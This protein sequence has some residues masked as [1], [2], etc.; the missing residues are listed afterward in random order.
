MKH[1]QKAVW[2]SLPPW[3]QSVIV[4]VPSIFQVKKYPNSLPFAVF[5]FHKISFLTIWINIQKLTNLT[6]QPLHN[7]FWSSGGSLP[8]LSARPL[9]G[10]LPD[11]SGGPERTNN[12]SSIRGN[13]R[14][15]V[16]L[17]A[18]CLDYKVIKIGEVL[19]L[20]T[21]FC[22]TRWII[23]PVLHHIML[24]NIGKLLNNWEDV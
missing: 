4:I 6:W 14:R 1:V 20:R 13:S 23:Y 24:C 3:N 2:R 12:S 9:T 21:H 11:W 15:M 18:R 16:P 22:N 17:S 8:V 5:E 19:N 10:P 7:T